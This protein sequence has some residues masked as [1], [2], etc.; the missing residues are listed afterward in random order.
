MNDADATARQGRAKQ[1]ASEQSE[2]SHVS[3]LR[4]PRYGAQDGTAD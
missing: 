4:A 3:R 1:D 2:A